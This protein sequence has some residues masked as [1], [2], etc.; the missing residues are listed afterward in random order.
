MGD[1]EKH[2]GGV[3]SFEGG[4]SPLEGIELRRYRVFRRFFV[5]PLGAR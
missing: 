1:N 2:I 4:L 5:D 3:S